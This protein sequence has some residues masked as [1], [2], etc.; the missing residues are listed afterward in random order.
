MDEVDP[1]LSS[2][3]DYGWLSPL[4]KILL[5]ML[6]FLYGYLNNYGWAIV[7]LTLIIRLLMLPLTLKGAKA[8]EKQKEFQRKMQYVEQKYKH[9]T[10]ALNRE[11]MELTSKYGVSNML[12]CLPQLAQLPILLGLNRLLSTSVE[13][14]QAPF[15][16]WITDL[17]ARD[18]YYILPLLAG[19]GLLIQVVA[20]SDARRGITMLLF[21]A[22]LVAV[23]A[24]LSAGLTL[25]LC[26]N[27][28]FAIG[29]TY[30]QKAFKI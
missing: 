12:G 28:W 3:L 7:V 16:G 24:H 4:V 21:A 8:M 30:L 20:D 29:Q 17:S 13:L 1:R 15:M 5:A 22:L 2:S 11:R 6:K 25:Y 9:D 14:Y 10:E 27:T 26:A 19:A 18:P 23:T